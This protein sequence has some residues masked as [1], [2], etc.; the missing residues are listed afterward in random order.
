VAD[1]TASE[2]FD[3]ARFIEPPWSRPLDAELAI[4]AIPETAQVRGLLIAPMV[5]EAKKRGPLPRERYLSFNLYPLREHAQLLVDTSRARFAD[6]PLREALRRLGRGAHDA[7]GASTL[8]KVTLAAA[9]GI[10]D[11]IAAFAKGYELNLQPGRAEVVDRGAQ[12]MIV[13][14]DEVHYFVD[15]HHV[16]AFE[17]ALGRAGV[18]GRVRIAAH[19][20]TAAD[21]LLQ[22]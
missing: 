7:F 18:R 10:H 4:R 21:F 19:G 9:D 8:G 5:A 2:G 6:L 11:V 20:R 22:W 17:G 14:L 3:L 12:H 1:R 15:S 16:G 13:R